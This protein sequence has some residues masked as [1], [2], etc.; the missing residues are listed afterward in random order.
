MVPR[1]KVQKYLNLISMTK[2]LR[3]GIK[4]LLRSVRRTFF[5]TQ[6]CDVLYSN[7]QIFDLPHGFEEAVKL[8]E[9]YLL[10]KKKKTYEFSS[11]IQSL[12]KVRASAYFLFNVPV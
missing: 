6:I 11:R 4:N 1:K 2:K 8:V 12:K 5:F 10:R 9:K 3:S 7:W